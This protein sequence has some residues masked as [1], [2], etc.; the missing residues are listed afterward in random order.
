MCVDIRERGSLWM[1][2]KVQNKTEELSPTTNST[3]R[4]TNSVFPSVNL[5]E[6]ETSNY[7]LSLLC[8]LLF[9]STSTNKWILKWRGS[10]TEKFFFL[11]PFPW[12][13]DQFLPDFSP[14]YN[15]ERNRLFLFNGL[16][17]NIPFLRFLV[18]C[19]LVL[20]FI[21]CNSKLPVMNM[22]WSSHSLS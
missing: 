20:S 9:P 12:P 14:K 3:Q 22:R 17:T 16:N 13:N 7:V 10:G 6:R 15:F 19:F 2:M 18:F 11:F 8:F 5:I 4:P 1:W 21:Y